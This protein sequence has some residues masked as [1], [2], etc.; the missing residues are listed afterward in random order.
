MSSYEVKLF[1]SQFC[2]CVVVCFGFEF[3]KREVTVCFYFPKM[4]YLFPIKK[5]GY[6]LYLIVQI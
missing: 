6:R 4:T 2:V 1:D 3:L 5:H